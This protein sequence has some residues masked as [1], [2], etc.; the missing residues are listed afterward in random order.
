MS[1]RR[2]VQEFTSLHFASHFLLRQWN[3]KKPTINID[4]WVSD[5]LVI[6]RLGYVYLEKK[7]NVNCMTLYK[8][9]YVYN[10]AAYNL[11]EMCR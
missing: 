11:A 4:F 5:Q 9:Y 3:D 8:S 10:I 2:N 1:H 7:I 6:Q